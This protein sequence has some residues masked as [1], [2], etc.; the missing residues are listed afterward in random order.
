MRIK[1]EFYSYSESD[2][3]GSLMAGVYMSTLTPLSMT[4]KAGGVGGIPDT[5]QLGQLTGKS[6]TTLFDSLLFPTQ[7]PTYTIPTIA[8]KRI[9]I[10][11]EINFSPSLLTFCKIFNNFV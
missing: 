9:F 11:F 5:T 1:K 8:T 3:S 6:F 7:L 4:V 2:P 10:K